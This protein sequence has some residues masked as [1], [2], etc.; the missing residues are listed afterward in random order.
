MLF[1]VFKIGDDRYALDANRV[2]EVLPLLTMKQMP[3][4]PPGFAGVFNYRGRPVPAL[5]LC[6]LTLG[7]PAREQL[8]TR[9][10]LVSYPGQ[11]SREHL[12]GL[13]AEHATQVLRKD[14][15]EFKDGGF[16]LPDAPYLGPVLMEGAGSIQ[17]IYE[18]HLLSDTARAAL[19]AQLP[20]VSA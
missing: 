17:R 7:R 9:I 1:L 18:Q 20:Q 11:N 16:T 15:S 19:F 6:Q 2:V 8:S 5:D 14:A 12:L 10:I 13:I 4:A 3:H